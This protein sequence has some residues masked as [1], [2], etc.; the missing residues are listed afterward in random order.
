MLCSITRSARTYFSPLTQVCRVARAFREFLYVF[1]DATTALSS[2]DYPS[3]NSVVIFL[4]VITMDLANK[5][6][7]SFFNRAVVVTKQKFVKY[8]KDIP[9]ALFRVHCLESKNQV[10]WAQNSACSLCMMHTLRRR[11][12]PHRPG[13]PYS[14]CYF[15]SSLVLSPYGVETYLTMNYSRYIEKVVQD[16]INVRS[17]KRVE[18]HVFQFFLSRFMTY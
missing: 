7:D 10:E 11:C 3:S 1:S 5:E 14:L 6:G 15:A 12:R 13:Y 8:Y 9:S 16:N 18:L 17:G 2:N 4:C